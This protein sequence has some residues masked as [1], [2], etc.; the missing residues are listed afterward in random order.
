VA[1]DRERSSAVVSAL[2]NIDDVDVTVERL[3]L[4]DY[5]VGRHLVIERKTLRDFSRSVRN[6]RLFRQVSR[7]ART[8]GASTCLVLEGTF[9]YSTLAGLTRPALLGAMVT[10][11]L[12]FGVPVLCT[13]DAEESARLLRI[14]GRQLQQ[15]LRAPCR[16]HTREDGHSRTT[17]VRMLL[18]VRDIGPVK[19]T[20]LLDHL[21]S[22]RTIANA[23]VEELTAVPGIGPKSARRLHWAFTNPITR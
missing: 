10:V 1:D 21:G 15:R 5:L 19:A 18:A 2:R 20:A 11:T 8:H 14:A 17:Q 22:L 6:G 4:G 23:T 13:R 9:S 3:S 12:L 16:H 7:L